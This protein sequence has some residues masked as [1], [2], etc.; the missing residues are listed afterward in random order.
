MTI[1]RR[2]TT[3]VPI[4][5]EVRRVKRLTPGYSEVVEIEA[6]NE[7][8][9]ARFRYKRRLKVVSD[10]EISLEEVEPRTVK[11]TTPE[12]FAKFFRGDI[13]E[14]QL[15]DAPTER[16]FIGEDINTKML[17]PVYEEKLFQI[18]PNRGR[19]DGKGISIKWEPT[20]PP[21]SRK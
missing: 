9:R 6:W 5:G 1:K 8:F 10:E 13:S 11:V 12:S 15:E 17:H 20:L 2:W 16:R 21:Q 18:Q 4:F 3:R 7:D 19:F 14:S